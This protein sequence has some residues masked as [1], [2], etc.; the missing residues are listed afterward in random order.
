MKRMQFDGWVSFDSNGR[1]PKMQRMSDGD[2]KIPMVRLSPSKVPERY[3][4]H[5]VLVTIEE[6]P[7]VTK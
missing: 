3:K 7:E 1:I 5:R 2:G 4:A 6:Y